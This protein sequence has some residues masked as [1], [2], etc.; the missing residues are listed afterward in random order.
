MDLIDRYLAV[1]DR[2]AAQRCPDDV[3]AEARRL[4]LIRIEAREAALGRPLRPDE[5]SAELAGFA[6]RLLAEARAVMAR[7]EDA[8]LGQEAPAHDILK[9]GSCGPH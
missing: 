1:A 2:C 8:C 7:L 3:A 9:G 5:A 6:K 4:L